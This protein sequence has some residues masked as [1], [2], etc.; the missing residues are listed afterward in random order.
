M[1]PDERLRRLGAAAGIAGPLLLAIYFTAPA[2]TNWPY[3]GAS[4]DVLIRYARDHQLLF[5]AGG[6]L[7]GTGSLLS[8]I[9]LLTLLQLSGARHQ[10]AGA[11]TIVGCGVLLALVV[12]EAALLEAVP[13]AAR[14]GDS[15]TVATTFALS[16]GVFARI[17]PLAPAPLVFVGIGLALTSSDLLPRLF[18]QSALVIAALFEIA[19]LAAVFSIVGLIL[20]I[21]MSIVEALWLLGAAVALARTTVAAPT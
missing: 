17:F 18:G 20:A 8:V 4:P 2:V 9:F 6:W 13:I 7:Q 5:F 11:L 15:A 3:A 21:V 1:L 12:V 10:I 14:A 19:G 16:N